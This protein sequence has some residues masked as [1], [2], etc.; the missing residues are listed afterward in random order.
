MD[1]PRHPDLRHRPPI[2]EAKKRLTHL[3]KKGPTPHAFSFKDTFS[4][5]SELAEA[6]VASPVRRE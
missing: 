2:E 4:P 5:G 6:H 3:A 1:H